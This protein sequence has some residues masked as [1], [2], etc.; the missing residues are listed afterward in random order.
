MNRNI[1][2]VGILGL[3]VVLVSFFTLYL[4]LPIVFVF[5]FGQG[6]LITLIYRALFIEENQ[7]N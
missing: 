7:T 3:L 5:L 6:S 1:H 2:F 4:N